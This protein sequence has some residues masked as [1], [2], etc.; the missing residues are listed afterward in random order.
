[1]PYIDFKLRKKVKLWEGV[2]GSLF[3]S[4]KA[5]FAHVT[6]L[7]GAI[8]A[9]HQHIQEQWTHVIEGQLLFNL[10]GEEKLLTAGMTAFMPSNVP[11]SAKAITEC[12]VIDCFLPVREDFVEL[13]K[14]TP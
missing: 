9:E 14:Q 1:M 4:E 13:E 11:H 5:T 3:H 10:N 7:K 12:K 2:S 8:V 6:L